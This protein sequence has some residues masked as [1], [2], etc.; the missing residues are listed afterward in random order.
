MKT[1]LVAILALA[2]VLAVSGGAAGK[3]CGSGACLLTPEAMARLEN[4]DSV[5]RQTAPPKIET[6]VTQRTTELQPATPAS[7]R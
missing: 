4:G 5:R 6:R 7:S 3:R 1:E 2:A